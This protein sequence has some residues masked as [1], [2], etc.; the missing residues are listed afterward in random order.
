MLLSGLSVSPNSGP[1]RGQVVPPSLRPAPS[2]SRSPLR[3]ATVA[4]EG[5]NRALIVDVN[6]PSRRKR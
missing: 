2:T 3:S 6:A 1:H 5:G 4:E